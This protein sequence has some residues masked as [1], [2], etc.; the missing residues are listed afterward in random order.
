MNIL[1]VNLLN[2]FIEASDNPPPQRIRS[3]ISNSVRNCL[4]DSCLDRVANIAPLLTEN[5]VKYK[6]KKTVE[7]CKTAKELDY[8]NYFRNNVLLNKFKLD[9]LKYIA[10]HNALKITGT[11]TVLIERISELFKL[12]KP[13]VKI[14]SVFRRWIVQES[15]KMR[16][17]SLK[18]RSVCVNDTDFVSMEP[19]DEIPTELFY[20]YQDSKSFIYGFNLSSLIQVLQRNI[21][22][23][24]KMENPYNREII[25]GRVVL[26]ILRLYRF[27]F[28]IYPNFIKENAKFVKN[29]IPAAIRTPLIQR[30]LPHLNDFNNFRADGQ[31][32]I[33]AEYTPVITA[34]YL[35][36]QDQYERINRLR[37]IRNMTI[38][39]RV[40]NLFI[41]I[42]HLGNYTQASWFNLLERNEYI[43]FYRNLYEIW[44]YRNMFTRDVRYG[45]C[46]F[47][48]PF[49]NVGNIR[50]IIYNMNTADL[51]QLCL[52]S[53]ENLVYTG[54]DDDHRKLGT[55]HALSA[56][57]LV[58][59]GARVSLPWLYDSV[60]L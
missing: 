1:P 41:E 51:K 43:I 44:Y 49:Y 50:N 9:E 40:N 45:I 32:I 5:V 55:M 52:I 28:I 42:D 59:L 12:T 39:Q 16:G 30:A 53:F 58:S 33:F 47:L 11:K 60:A 4:E 10:K 48:S 27:C 35:V 14:Q 26:Q 24:E 2:Q 13:V 31:A 37:E 21:R 20:S 38:D 6:K 7:I 22:A 25:D 19:I 17:P 46:P 15:L 36:S 18:K 8:V 54:V 57:T 29:I 23:N 56:L 34:N 3:P